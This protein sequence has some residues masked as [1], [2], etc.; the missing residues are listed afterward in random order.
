MIKF[1]NGHFFRLFVLICILLGDV[2]WVVSSATPSTE[3]VRLRNALLAQSGKPSDFTWLP[4]EHP[5]S[6][7]QEKLPDTGQF[8]VISQV[9]GSD[10][11]KDKTEFEKSLIIARHLL[12]V[13]KAK[14]GGILK[15]SYT[16][17][18]TIIK[19]GTGYC[20][21]FT[22]VFNAIAHAESIPV[23]EWGMSFDG[24]GGW[25]HAFNEI[26]DFRLKKWIFIDVFNGFYVRNRRDG[27]LL[28]VLEFRDKLINNLS[29]DLEIVPIKKNR[30]GFRDA[31]QALQYF[32]RG[33][34]QFYLYWGNNVNSY[35]S[36]PLIRLA[37]P[38][39]RHLEQITAVAIGIH[40]KIKII[41]TKSNKVLIAQLFD[42]KIKL[43]SAFIGA[44]ILSIAIVLQVLGIFR[45]DIKN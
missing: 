10:N 7:L 26:Y 20:A 9:I 11:V 1:L 15:D 29:A 2:L 22:Q 37:T 38:I 14:G 3:A 41:E 43:I 44:V 34:D 4:D 36:H 28:S 16:A 19:E 17:Y 30:F 8:N 42:L 25:G 23:R 35:E 39:S 12:Q 45:R 18:Q 5:D 31:L 24:F 13:D 6:Y 33:K 40:P 21:D 32:D 27:Q